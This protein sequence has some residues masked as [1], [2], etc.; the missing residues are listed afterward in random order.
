MDT[1][2]QV[3]I[4]TKLYCQIETGWQVCFKRRTQSAMHRKA[5]LAGQAMSM[6]NSDGPLVCESCFKVGKNR[7]IDVIKEKYHP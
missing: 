7:I 4:L 1:L 6:T 2:L 3:C 5:L